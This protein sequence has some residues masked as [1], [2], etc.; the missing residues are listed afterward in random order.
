[1]PSENVDPHANLP[2][3]VRYWVLAI[4]LVLTFL[5]YYDRQCFMR[6]EESIRTDLRLSP[7]QIGLIMGAFWLAYA[8]FELPGGWMGDRFGAR[9]TLTRIVMA[10]SLLT[11]LTGACMGFTS[12]FLCRFMF[13]VG[14]AGAFPNIARVQSRWLPIVTREWAGGLIWLTARWGG[15]FAPLIFGAI[16]AMF[17]T[18]AEEDYRTAMKPALLLRSAKDQVAALRRNLEQQPLPL[19]QQNV[20]ALEKVRGQVH[21]AEMLLTKFGEANPKPELAQVALELTKIAQ[22]NVRSARQAL[23]LIPTA[24]VKQEQI[25]NTSVAKEQIDAA[26]AD[27][28]TIQTQLKSRFPIASWRLAFFVS[29]LLGVAWVIAFWPWFRDHPSEK[30]SVNAAELELIT[31]NVPA[32]VRGHSMPP[33]MWRA[34]LTNRSLWAMGIYYLCGSFGWS[35]FA[36]WMLR[37]FDEVQGVSYKGSAWMAAAPMFLGGISCLVG[38]IF[39]RLLIRATGWRRLGRALFPFCGALTAAATMFAVPAMNTPLKATILLCIVYVAYDFGQGANWSTIIDIGGKYAGLAA[40]MINLIGNIG[41]AA[42]PFIGSLIIEKFG[43]PTMFAV[44]SMAFL[45]A[46]SMWLLIDP[47]R[48]FY[49]GRPKLNLTPDP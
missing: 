23:E 10:W 25:N 24:H 13:G 2:S 49:E 19:A 18:P 37:Y 29:G 4:L 42:Q 21:Q 6:A 40:G 30:S 22:G 12:L 7:P 35:F 9:A 41:N 16:M 45:L 3:R 47:R 33:G 34:L 46:G 15:A 31:K 1:M 14:E 43:W 44:Y 39:S 32:E 36:S 26:I 17:Q 48:T 20:K 38:G 11:S 8:L 28:E 27:M 5:T